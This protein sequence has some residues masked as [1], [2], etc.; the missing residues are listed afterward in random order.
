MGPDSRGFTLVEIMIAVTI[1]GITAM[2]VMPA[3]LSAAHRARCARTGSDMRTFA[4]AFVTYAADHGQYPPDS[5]LTLP[6]GMDDYI[7]TGKWYAETALGGHWNWDSPSSYSYAGVAI[8]VH[9]CTDDELRVLDA[10]VDD[11]NLA[12]G[13]IIKSSHGRPTYIIE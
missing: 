3:A 12:T 8:F 10:M 7:D 4:N 11:G 9:D 1:I 5:H 2:L 6:P 13:E